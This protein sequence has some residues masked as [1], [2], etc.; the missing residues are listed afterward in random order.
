MSAKTVLSMYISY[1]YFVV[2][3]ARITFF[4]VSYI[5][6]YVEIITMP[7]SVDSNTAVL[8]NLLPVIN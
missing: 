5:L 6:I 3:V 4:Y 8:I 1:Y 2:L 7:W